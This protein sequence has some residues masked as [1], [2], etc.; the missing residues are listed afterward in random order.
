[1]SR[2]SRRSATADAFPRKRP[3]WW[4]DDDEDY[5]EEATTKDDHEKAKVGRAIAGVNDAPEKI[6]CAEPLRRGIRLVQLSG[7]DSQPS[8]LKASYEDEA[9]KPVPF[10]EAFFAPEFC[11]DWNDDEEEEERYQLDDEEDEEDEKA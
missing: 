7:C 6:S 2:P 5:E 11:L 8:M 9:G 10:D 1:L 3:G 4:P